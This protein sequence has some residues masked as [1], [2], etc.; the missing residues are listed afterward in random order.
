[1]LVYYRGLRTGTKKPRPSHAAG[2]LDGQ[3]QG[4]AAASKEDVH[5]PLLHWTHYDPDTGAP[6]DDKQVASARSANKLLPIFYNSM[7]A[8]DY[9]VIDGLCRTSIIGPV[10]DSLSELIVGSGFKPELELIEPSG[11]S[12]KDQKEL[13]KYAPALKELRAVQ[14]H[15]D[16]NNDLHFVDF[17]AML[18]NNCLTYGR[19]ALIYGSHTMYANKIPTS[20]KFAHA[21]DLSITVFDEETWRLES[22]LWQHGGSTPLP[23]GSMIYLWTPL[24]TARYRSAWQYGGSLVLPMLDAARALRELSQRTSRQ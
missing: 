13:A 12:V 11:D 15:I 16:D 5:E 3:S 19:S 24:P 7:Q 8:I 17:A 4:R 6:M 14:R 23:A 20:L 10:M 22:V 9:Q 21:R 2:P 18:M 1:M